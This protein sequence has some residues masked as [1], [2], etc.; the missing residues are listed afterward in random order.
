M[1]NLII[2][3]VGAM[4]IV[5]L[6]SI[7][8]NSTETQSQYAIANDGGYVPV[9]RVQAPAMRIGNVVEVEWRGE[10]YSAYLTPESEIQTGDMI[11]CTFL[12]YEGNVEFISIER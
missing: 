6:I 4:L 2:L 1:R 5:A 7:G 10:T 12:V 11:T 8:N 9:Y 3:L